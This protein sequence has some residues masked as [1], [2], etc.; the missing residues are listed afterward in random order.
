[1]IVGVLAG[2][3][4][5]RLYMPSKAMSERSGSMFREAVGALITLPVF[6]EIDECLPEIEGRGKRLSVGYLLAFL[7]VGIGVA[8]G[9][10]FDW[11]GENS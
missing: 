9:H 8:F 7:S 5:H 11:I 1:M 3:A 6:I 10:L 2:Y 4:G